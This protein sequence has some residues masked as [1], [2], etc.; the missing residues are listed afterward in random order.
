MIDVTIVSAE[1]CE[2]LTFAAKAAGFQTSWQDYTLWVRRGNDLWTVWEPLHHDGQAFRLALELK[3]P[4]HPGR[5][6]KSYPASC[7]G[8][9][10]EA[11]RSVTPIS[12]PK[13]TRR[14]IVEVAAEVGK[15]MQEAA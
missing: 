6:W 7:R 12:D 3:M 14:A 15:A 13:D 4:I 10:A 2:L 8:G 5:I 11:S 1:D 9:F